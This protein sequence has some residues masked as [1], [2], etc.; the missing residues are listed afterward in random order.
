MAH[1]DTALYE[2]PPGLRAALRL[3][4]RSSRGVSALHVFDFDGTLVR[5]PG[6]DE[7]KAL[8]RAATG[9]AWEGGWWGRSGSLS[10]PVLPSPLP[11]SRVVRTVFS[12]FVEI[13]L[14]SQSACAVIATGRLK[15][16]RAEV[17]RVLCDAA[18]A[19]VGDDCDVDTLLPSDLLF[20]H[21]GGG[22]STLQYKCALFR[23]LVSDDALSSLTHLHIWEDRREHAEYFATTFASTLPSLT[24]TVHFIPLDMP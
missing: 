7:G 14:H 2:L 4:R 18:R 1:Q 16:L 5:T 8:Y 15:K 11:V 10:P 20:T 22:R 19:H 6:L 17:H 9:N 13:A 24:V 3:D 12:E 21:P 23:S